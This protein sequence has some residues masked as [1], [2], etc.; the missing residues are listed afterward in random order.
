MTEEQ[1]EQLFFALDYLAV[2]ILVALAFATVAMILRSAGP[3]RH[4]KK[5]GK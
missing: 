1:L 2:G 4:P 3:R 5:G